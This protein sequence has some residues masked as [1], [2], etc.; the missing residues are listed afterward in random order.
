MNSDTDHPPEQTNREPNE[1]TL[2]KDSL[3]SSRILIVDDNPAI[4]E[5]FRKILGEQ[6]PV[7][8]RLTE[9]ETRLFGPSEVPVRRAGFRMDSAYQGQDGLR[10]LQKAI[11]EKDPYA[12]AFVDVRMPPG[13]DGLETLE[14]FWKFCPDVQAVICTAYSDYSWE[15]ITR[16]LKQTD[17]LLILKKPFDAI[18]ALQVAHAMTKK[19]ELGR[20]AKLRME[21]LDRMVTERTHE[22]QAE[23]D[24]RLRVQEHLR[25]TEERFAKAFNASPLPMA[26]QSCDGQFLDANQSFLELTA[27]DSNDLI[28]RTAGELKLWPDND[29]KILAAARAEG[30]FRNQQYVLNRRDGKSRTTLMWTEPITLETGPSQL[31][32]VE[33]IT[34]RLK[35]ESQL[36]QAQKME[37]VGCLATGIAHEFNNLLTVIQGHAGLLRNG[38]GDGRFR[39]DS[40]ERIT[41]ASLEAA[42]L[43]RRLLTFSRKQPLQLKPINLSKTL[44]NMRRMLSRLVGER[45]QLQV[46]CQAELPSVQADEPSFQQVVIN[47]V[48]NARD[49]MPSGGTIE[50]ETSTVTLDADAARDHVDARPGRFG[51]LSIA[52]SGCGMTAEVAGRVF[53]PFFTTKEVGKGTGL[54]LSA[55]HG[56]VQQH[57]GWIQVATQ[58]DKGSTFKIFLPACETTTDETSAPEFVS[59][60]ATGGSG[61][62]VLLVEDEPSV[63]ELARLTLEQGGY[64]VFEA[65]NG[66]EALTVWE[67][68]PVRIDLLV[69]DMVM[70]KGVTGAELAK[71]LV[72]KDPQLRSIVTSGYSSE[73]GHDDELPVPGGRFL[74]KPYDPLTLLRTVKRSLDG[75]DGA[76][77]AEPSF[78]AA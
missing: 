41:Q 16:R 68:S 52:D 22:L 59:Q 53:E 31:L 67:K 63:R 77:A 33:D 51:C 5:D 8:S 64:R 29:T 7:V 44:E 61:E 65:A 34:D 72:K 76:N 78:S 20:Q 28:G 39:A 74:S 45:Y 62:A 18:E 21:D 25:H 13:W 47:L 57:G 73:A 58:P 26:I 50:V 43:T 11:E 48:L 40:V 49:S 35:L 36:R 69:T 32:I 75:R 37:A 42:S 19:W 10:M 6:M 14:H 55:V 46:N 56:I 70:P 60:R 71:A 4:H 27:Y 54:G 24:E 2:T 23:V 9:L 1:Q 66:P 3:P 30:R 17:N 15:Q 38:S 12:L